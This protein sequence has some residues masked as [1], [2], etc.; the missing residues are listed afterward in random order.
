[1]RGSKVLGI[2][3]RGMQLNQG[4]EAS[5]L[6]PRAEEVVT[7]K[8]EGEEIPCR[9]ISMCKGPVAGGCLLSEKD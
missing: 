5:D 6:E 4:R 7:R 1:M 9:S 8:K 3:N 2:S